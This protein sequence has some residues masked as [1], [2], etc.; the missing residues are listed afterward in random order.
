M[1]EKYIHN[2]KVTLFHYT[3]YLGGENEILDPVEGLKRMQ[4]YSKR[5]YATSN[6]PRTFFYLDPTEKE[7]YVSAKH[8]YV[9]KVSPEDVYDLTVDAD[10]IKDQWSNTSP[11]N[12]NKLFEA[13]KEAGYKAAAYTV[14]R[15]IVV[16]FE[17]LEVKRI[18]PSQFLK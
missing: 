16:Y 10:L 3:N 7:H 17:P 11:G 5:E 14:N 13:I 18:D 1:L 2:G 6:V 4:T 15:D 9:A 12:Y 8:L